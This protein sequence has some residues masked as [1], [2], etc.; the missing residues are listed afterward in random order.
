M[1]LF[2]IG[3]VLLV[4][5]YYTYGRF[6]ERILQPDDRPTPAIVRE[7]GVDFVPLPKWKNALIQLLNIAGV[8]PVIGVIL[9]IKFGAIVFL[10]IP[11]GNILGGAVHDYV[12]GMMSLR[13]N[14]SNL[15]HQIKINLG[16]FYYC[17]F[18]FFM[19][20]LLL[21]VVTV[22][23]NVPTQILDKHFFPENP[24]FW[25]IA[26]AI[27]V[28]Y[29]LATLFPIDKIIGRIYPFFG[30][31]LILGTALLFVSL[32]YHNIVMPG[33]F[34][35]ETPEI[36]AV[37]PQQGPI[38]P[39]LFVTI[40]CGILSGFHA[41]QSPIVARTMRSER[42]ARCTFY[43]MMVL[44][45]VI[46]MIWAAGGMA[47]YHLFPEFL[48]K[49]PPIVLTEITTYFLGGWMSTVTVLAVVILAITSGDTAL[50]SLRLSLSEFCH[51]DQKPLGKRF[52]VCLPLMI[53]IAGMLYWSNVDAKSFDIL[54]KYFAWGNQVLAAS[55]LLAC[56]V[57][58]FAMRRNF[59]ITLLPGLFMTFV[60][61]SY[62]LWTSPEHGGPVGIGLSLEKAYATAAI[63]TFLLAVWTHF[64]ARKVRRLQEKM[65]DNDIMINE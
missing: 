63:L 19:A 44:E 24:L 43:G 57:W 42:E 65:V 12:S 53:L 59:W 64:R 36:Q 25:W 10:I 22:F 34:L 51:L 38:I 30:G 39:C 46:A 50:R 6:V 26:A 45:G 13:N 4:V 20:F 48:E 52:A 17:I 14:G 47:I 31:M 16:R 29:I 61:L 56:T 49:A 28:Y 1:L 33:D 58:L 35:R 60:V 9:G 11:I 27:F 41:T 32:V 15:P 23:V 37:I 40:A 7:D 55:T 62:I 3:I 18:A 54:W 21:L 5:G 2:L 8:G